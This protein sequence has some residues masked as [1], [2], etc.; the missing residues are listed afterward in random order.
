MWGRGR[1]RLAAPRCSA[2]SVAASQGATSTSPSSGTTAREGHYTGEI[3]E[4][5]FA[6]GFAVDEANPESRASWESTVPFKCVAQASQGSQLNGTFNVVIDNG[7]TVTWVIT[8]TCGS[9]DSCAAQVR[10]TEGG[11]KWIAN[12]QLRENRPDE[13]LGPAMWH[14][15]VDR[16][17]GVNCP[18][19]GNVPAQYEY[20]WYQF[21]DNNGSPIATS[22][23]WLNINWR[24]TLCE[25][26][27]RQHHFSVSKA[28]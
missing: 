6:R 25:P 23:G 20:L 18:E 16:P 28:G 13:G 3:G 4:G 17:D 1:P 19:K 5:D 22:S 26:G 8:S 15:V 7:P 9:G 14:M 21:T 10:Q 2:T 24:N 11:S 27:F 12:A